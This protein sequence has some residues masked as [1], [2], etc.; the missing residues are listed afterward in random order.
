MNLG[1]LPSL[2]WLNLGYNQLGHNQPPSGFSFLASLVNSTRLE[3]LGLEA[4]D[5]SGEIP[6]CIANLSTTL[7]QLVLSYN[8][9][10]G[11][12]PRG[13][14]K[15]SNITY[16]TFYQNMLQG[17]VHESICKLSKLGSLSLGFNNLSGVIPAC[18]SNITGLL[19]LSLES[20]M[21]HG[22]ISASLFNISSLEGLDLHSNHLSGVI[23][24]NIIGLSHIIGLYLDQN[25]LTGPLPSN[26]GSLIK[27]VNLNVSDNELAGEI[28]TSLGDCVMLKVLYMGKNLFEGSIPSSFKALRSLE[29]LDISSNNI[30]GNIPQFLGEFALVQF[31]NLSHNKLGGEVPK[32]GLFSNVSAFSVVGN[33][34]LCGGIEALQ[35]PSCP[36]N[37]LKTKKEEFPWRLIPLV[38]LLPLATLLACLTFVFCRI[39]KSK[40]QNGPVFVL[41]DTKYPRLSYQDLTL[42]TLGFSQN[43]LLGQGGYGSVYKGILESESLQQIVAVKVLNVEVHGANKNFLAECEMLRNIRHRNLIKIITACS[44]TD[45]KGNDFKALVLEFMKNGSLDKWLHPSPSGQENKKNLS[46]FQRLNIAIDIALALDYLHHQ[47]PTK[48]IH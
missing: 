38:V 26:F 31:L 32:K 21:F 2:E 6:N 11:T 47:C 33:Y 22:R 41:Q 1:H 37:I 3:F 24:E 18:L 36:P 14:G 16:L 44:S 34:R 27:L 42:A 46:L 28:P 17:S 9:I 30:S 12:I 35:L 43:N 45:I 10:Y 7:D 8:Y 13:I 25:L 15:F 5:F 19:L 48:I 40:Q 29:V 23:P 4:N 20:N 39:K